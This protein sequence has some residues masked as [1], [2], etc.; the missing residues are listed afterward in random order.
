MPRSEAQKRADKKYQSKYN[1]EK[2]TNISISVKRDEGDLYKAAARQYGMPTAQLLR[3]Y[4]IYCI[5]H[6]IDP[7]ETRAD[8]QEL[9]VDWFDIEK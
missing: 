1:K 5:K 7:R 6:R 9:D 8:I 2:M 4:A 3:R